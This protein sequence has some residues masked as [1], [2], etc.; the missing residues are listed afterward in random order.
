MILKDDIE[1]LNSERELPKDKDAVYASWERAG[2]DNGH[3]LS[4]PNPDGYEYCICSCGWSAGMPVR[5]DKYKHFIEWM[6]HLAANGITRNEIFWDD[7]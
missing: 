3:T 4:R 2:Y 6:R 7:E 1:M 5:N